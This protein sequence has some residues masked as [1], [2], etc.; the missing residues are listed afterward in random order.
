MTTIKN[1]IALLFGL[2][3]HAIAGPVEEST[4]SFDNDIHF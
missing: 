3:I 1:I 4:E 2:L